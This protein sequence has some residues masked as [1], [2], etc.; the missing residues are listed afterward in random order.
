MLAGGTDNG[1]GLGLGLEAPAPAPAVAP[2]PGMAVQLDRGGEKAPE[3]RDDSDL[4]VGDNTTETAREV[5]DKDIRNTLA[6]DTAGNEMSVQPEDVA[7]EEEGL[8]PTDV[9]NL[10]TNGMQP[11]A[12]R[13]L[14]DKNDHFPSTEMQPWPHS[15]LYTLDNMQF[16]ATN[17]TENEIEEHRKEYGH[18]HNLFLMSDT[19]VRYRAEDIEAV[20]GEPKTVDGGAQQILDTVLSFKSKT[21]EKHMLRLLMIYFY[22]GPIGKG[23]KEISDEDRRN[24]MRG[25]V[26]RL[27]GSKGYTLS[28]VKY[29][30]KPAG[31][32][33]Q[34]WKPVWSGSKLVKELEKYKKQLDFEKCMQSESWTDVEACVNK[35]RVAT[36]A[37]FMLTAAFPSQMTVREWVS[38][39]WHYHFLTYQPMK[40]AFHDGETYSMGCKRCSRPFYEYQFLYAP[41]RGATEPTCMSFPFSLWEAEGSTTPVPFHDEGV[42]KVAAWPLVK[43]GKDGLQLAR[44][45]KGTDG[46]ADKRVPTKMN[47]PT[48]LLKDVGKTEARLDN[49]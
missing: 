12:P 10:K 16:K 41:M 45:S 47:W 29:G 38:T 2:A 44:H 42:L 9:K 5:V 40:A 31:D 43:A 14:G 19:A 1:A 28:D 26:W 46:V 37:K 39:P 8:S 48:F 22:N 27:K 17:M 20:Y 49:T 21:H 33:E 4:P 18:V 36:D 24:G 23:D 25:G 30:S 35:K 32:Y 3:E 11:G 6:P 15:D 34:I 13:G 7:V